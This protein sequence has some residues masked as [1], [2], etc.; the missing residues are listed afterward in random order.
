[1]SEWA[2]FTISELCRSDF[3]FYEK[4][5]E[6]K[7]ARIF[8]GLFFCGATRDECLNQHTFASLADARDIIEAWR[9]DYNELRPHRSLGHMTPNA[10]AAELETATLSSHSSETT[11]PASL[12]IA[13][14]A[15]ATEPRQIE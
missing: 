12:A 3:D 6:R 9:L 10:F 5:W 1:M 13:V 11:N 2:T 8:S 4:S 14:I 7:R 15:A